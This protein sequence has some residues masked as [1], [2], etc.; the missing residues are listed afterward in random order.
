[1]EQIVVDEENGTYASLDGVLFTKDYKTLVKY[2]SAR[3]GEV[4]IVPDVTVNIAA[5][6]FN[7]Y[8][9]NVELPNLKTIRLGSNFEEFGIAHYGYGYA[10]SENGN[11]RNGEWEKIEFYLKGDGKIYSKTG[12]E[13]VPAA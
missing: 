10:S 8:F 5:F 2:P 9:S 1:L 6:A 3:S 12:Q 13:F 4:Y 11:F 7:M